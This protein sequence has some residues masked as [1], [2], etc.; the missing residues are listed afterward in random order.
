MPAGDTPPQDASRPRGPRALGAGAGGPLPSPPRAPRPCPALAAGADGQP[1]RPL[2]AAA[3]GTARTGGPAAPGS[4]AELSRCRHG[5]G[6]RDHLS[7]RRY[8]AVGG[9]ALRRGDGGTRSGRAPGGSRSE[10]AASLP[11][12]AVR[13]AGNAVRGGGGSGRGGTAAPAAPRARTP[14]A[15]EAERGQAAAPGRGGGRGGEEPV[16]LWHLLTAAQP[17]REVSAGTRRGA[18][19]FP[20]GE[21]GLAEGTGRSCQHPPPRHRRLPVQRGMLERADVKPGWQSPLLGARLAFESQF[22]VFISSFAL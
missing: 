13:A 21:P 17:G 5:G 1:G 3:R 11:A 15:G 16:F 12:A 2:P 20:G 19:T 6:D 22:A 9:A 10:G 18:Q 4:G 8:E 7:R 14:G